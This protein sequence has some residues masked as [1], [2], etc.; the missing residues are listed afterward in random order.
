[1]IDEQTVS[2]L[3]RKFQTGQQNVIREY[4]QHIF[5]LKFYSLKGAERLPF[6]GG[7]ALRFVWGSPRFS[8]DLDFTGFKTN[9]R[10]I[11]SLIESTLAGIENEGI[12]ADLIESKPTTG[13]HWALVG[14]HWLQFSTEVSLQVS[15]R[16]ASGGK[17]SVASVAS[18]FMPDYTLVHLSE[19]SLVREKVQALLIRAKPRDFYDLYFILRRRL[20][21]EPVFGK[22]K[23]LKQKILSKMKGQPLDLK[24]EL[25]DF[26]PAS[27]HRLLKGFKETLK[28]EIERNLP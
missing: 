21:F 27:H 23:T 3:V 11:E 2:E 4:C 19:E 22:D 9:T 8:E 1:M 28:R 14:F 26:L 16:S 13:G 17:T 10:G 12:V 5:L 7:T 6:K 15:L 18:D 24:S 25:R 20:V